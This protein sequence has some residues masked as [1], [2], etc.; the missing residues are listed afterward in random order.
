MGNNYIPHIKIG[1]INKCPKD[2]GLGNIFRHFLW[3]KKNVIIF[4]I[5]H[6]SDIKIFLKLSITK[7]I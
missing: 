1:K 7:F 2:I 5:F 4:Y 6:K 3:E